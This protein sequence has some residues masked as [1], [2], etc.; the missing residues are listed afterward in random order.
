MKKYFPFLSVVAIINI[1]CVKNGYV[2]LQDKKIEDM[3]SKIDRLEEKIEKLED[4]DYQFY[5]EEKV[6]VD[7]AEIKL[8]KK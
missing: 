1:S 2:E 3:N 6:K 4:S 8:K 5:K 7:S